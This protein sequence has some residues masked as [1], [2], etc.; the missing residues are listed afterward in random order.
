MSKAADQIP[1]ARVVRRR[2]TSLAWIVP[3]LVLVGIVATL[4]VQ[5]GRERGPR[6]WIRFD[7]AAAL[8]P[9]AKIMH[10]GLGVGI[11]RE[12]RLTEDLR[13]VEVE[14]EL[15]P[16]A[17]KLAVAGSRFWIVRPEVSLQRVAGL[18][19]IIGPRYIAVRPGDANG[20]PERRFEGES[21]APSGIDAGASG[22]PITLRAKSASATSPGAA[23]VFR[24][25]PIGIV[26]G[27]SIAQDATHVRIDAEI[28]ER[29]APL[30]R[31]DSRFW[32]ASGVG[33]D[34]GWFTGISVQAG[35]LDT[36]LRGAIAM[37]TPTRLAERAEPG[38][39]FDLATEPEPAWLR[40]EPV[41]DLDAGDGGP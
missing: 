26:R 24:G 33:L 18:E 4:A 39:S 28:D 8:E 15:A 6:I 5:V 41:I 36:V 14:A 17:R 9:G 32:D 27:V 40:W 34:F 35:S 29:Y 1:A 37:A 21:T 25:M 3:V 11:V 7:D 13:A 30:V 20:S 22:L 16:S 10:R 19:T 31:T 38:A 12:I 2:R 23:I